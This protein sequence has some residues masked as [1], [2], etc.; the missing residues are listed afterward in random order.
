MYC[1][2]P[3]CPNLQNTGEPAEFRGDMESC[4]EC[5]SPL[6]AEFPSHLF[7]DGDDVPQDASDDPDEG[8]GLVMVG[9]CASPEHAE[10][11]RAVF[12]Q[13][14]LTAYLDDRILVGLESPIAPVLGGVKVRVPA[15]QA[16]VARRLMATLSGDEDEPGEIEH[17]P[18][19]DGQA[20]EPGD[21]E[22]LEDETSRLEA[23]SVWLVIALPLVIGLILMVITLMSK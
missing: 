2:N 13:Y 21:D 4:N 16:E 12:L 18:E 1:P 15:A 11:V 23:S 19:L 20:E 7:E 3:D 14:G 5:G 10:M 8:T 6:Q 9:A 17:S 22:E